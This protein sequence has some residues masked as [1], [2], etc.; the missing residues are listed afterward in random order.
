MLRST[1]EWE[2]TFKTC[3]GLYEWLVTPFDLSNAFSKFMCLM[4]ETLRP[5]I[6]YYE[7]VYFD[8]ILA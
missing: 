2:M 5:F 7:V 6:D 8:D 4:I 1:G 3:E